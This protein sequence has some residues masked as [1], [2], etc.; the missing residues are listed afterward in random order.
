MDTEDVAPFRTLDG[1]DSEG[2]CSNG[3]LSH[4]QYT[5]TSLG[6]E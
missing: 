2:S 6:Y 4:T 5:Q 3:T 1:R